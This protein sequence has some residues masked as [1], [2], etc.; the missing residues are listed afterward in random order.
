MQN[1]PNWSALDLER[2]EESPASSS[3]LFDPTFTP[4]LGASVVTLR[5]RFLRGKLKRV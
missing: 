5:V 1:S 4:G 2:L 3:P